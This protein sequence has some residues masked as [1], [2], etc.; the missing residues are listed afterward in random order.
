MAVGGIC[1]VRLSLLA[2]AVITLCGAVPPCTA[3]VGAFQTPSELLVGLR[4]VLDEACGKAHQLLVSVVGSRVIETTTENAKL[5]LHSVFDQEKLEALLEYFKV[6]V[7]FLSTGA[8]SGLNV[9]AVYV[10]EILSATGV[11]VKLPFPHFTAEGVAF[12]A[13]WALLAVIGYW[14]ISLCLHLVLCVLRRVLWLLKLSIALWLFVVIV[15]DTSASTNTTAWR[16]GALV[17]TCALLGLTQ[18]GSE[19]DRSRNLEKRVKG[20]EGSMKRI[21]R[22]LEE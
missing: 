17:F 12:V 19:Q 4:G 14:V 22:N 8:A 5:H 9:I 2:L 21:E 7:G 20:L 6:A 13:Q 16:L 3:D 10:T 1:K 18:V 11:S 15:S